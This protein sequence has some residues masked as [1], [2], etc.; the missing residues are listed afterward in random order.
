MSKAFATQIKVL[1]YIIFIAIQPVLLRSQRK[2]FAV[3]LSDKEADFQT[4]I[5]A[6]MRFL[7]RRRFPRPKVKTGVLDSA[8]GKGR[9][10]FCSLKTFAVT[11]IDAPRFTRL[12]LRVPLAGTEP[13]ILHY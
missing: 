7:L 4:G 12:A 6:G 1:F 13:H 11:G 10:G 9:I 8:G 3:R 5:K 2:D